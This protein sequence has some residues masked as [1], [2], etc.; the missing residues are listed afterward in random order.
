VLKGKPVFSYNL[1]ALEHFRWESPQALTGGKHTIMFDFK[2]D[3]PGL[4]KGGTG[5]LSVD[6]K[7]VARKTIPHTVPGIFTV[8]ES[9][10]VGIDTRFGVDDSYQPPFRFT[11]K[12]DKLKIKLEPSQL[13]DTDQKRAAEMVAQARD[14]R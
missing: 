14:D 4:A 8:D 11:G 2:Y 3:G 9:F 7:E 1:L 10:D 6:G 5:I 13:A 12:L